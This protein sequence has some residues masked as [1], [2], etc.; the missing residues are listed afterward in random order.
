MK[1]QTIG[2]CMNCYH[3]LKWTTDNEMYI[4][5]NRVVMCPNCGSYVDCSDMFAGHIESF[6]EVE[7]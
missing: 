5:G 2:Y 6:D 1:Y 7:E 4:N 3:K